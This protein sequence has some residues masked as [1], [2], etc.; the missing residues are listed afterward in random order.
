MKRSVLLRMVTAGP[1]I[2]AV[3]AGIVPWLPA[4]VWARPLIIG[5]FFATAVIRTVVAALTRS[6]AR[7]VPLTMAAGLLLFGI[8]SLVLALN[9]ALGFP[10]AAEVFFGAAYLCFTGYLIL[11][12]A[13]PGMWTLRAVL[14]TVVIAGGITSATLFALVTPLAGHL[15]AG[16]VPLLVALVYPLADAV[17]ITVVLTQLITRRRPRDPRGALLL[18][19]LCLLAAVDVSLPLGLGGGGYAFTTLQDV[20]WAA[21]QAMLAEAA[22]RPS[23]AAKSDG[24][25]GSG[26]PVTAAMVALLVLAV[27][28]D[29]TSTWLTRPPAAATMMA[30]LVLLLSSLRDARLATE[31]QRLSLTDD[32]TGLS[33]RRALLARLAVAQERPLSLMLID[34]N[35][36]KAVNDTFGHPEGDRLLAQ[37]GRRLVSV[38]PDAELV[39][40]LGGDEFAIVCPGTDA[41]AVSGQAEAVLAAMCMP[42]PI[43]DLGLTVSLAIGIASSHPDQV[44]GTELMRRAD[45][46]MYVAKVSGTGHQWYDG[47]ADSFSRDRLQLIEQLRVGIAEGQLRAFYQPQVQA[48]DGALVAVEA[49]VRWQ[50]PTRGLLTPDQFLPLAR[51]ARLMLPLS[52]EMIR[53]SVGQAADWAAAGAPLRLSLNVDPPELLSGAWVPALIAEIDRRRLDP[54]LITVELTEELLVSDPP[55]AAE[56]IHQLARHGV[57][58][59][60]DDYGTGY[61]GL[62]WLQTL[63]VTELKLARPFV[64]QILTDERTRMIVESTVQLANSLGLRVV[65]EGVED[66]ATAQAVTQMGAHLLQGYLV[67]RPLMA[68]TLHAW[69]TAR[70]TDARPQTPER[71]C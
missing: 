59:S 43:T 18:A 51:A 41:D 40:R 53:I 67:S 66:E 38:V 60:I 8:G 25:I 56:R 55:R 62:S 37:V 7:G 23:R 42:L 29:A 1:W 58:V 70:E 11:D 35:G 2:A 4:T 21:A 17:L 30:S 47:A 46:A 9:P 64:G 71:T 22:S 33:N 3:V 44:D 50:H 69:R 28:T 52:L 24:G 34:L 49:L 32:L 61:S 36:F 54:A 14:E 39:A 26:V 63:P 16:G 15:S 57:D 10:S 68:G 19:G 45:V 12:S 31:A 5:L 13:G 65:A 27:D 6:T 48:G 20:I